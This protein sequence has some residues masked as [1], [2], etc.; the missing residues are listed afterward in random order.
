M[1]GL[2][3]LFPSNVYHFIL[4]EDTNELDPRGFEFL[5]HGGNTFASSTKNIRVLEE[6]PKTKKIIL[7]K[8]KEIAKDLLGYENDFKLSTSWF[9]KIEKNGYANY[10]SH[11]NCFYSGIYLSLIHI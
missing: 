10:H 1:I 3:P 9:T 5:K 6:Y 8:F 7:N 2:L 4:E 11:R